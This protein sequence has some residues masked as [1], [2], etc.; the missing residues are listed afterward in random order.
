MRNN[1]FYAGV[2]QGVL[3]GIFSIIAK[4]YRMISALR[5]LLSSGCLF[6]GGRYAIARAL[7]WLLWYL[8]LYTNF[9][10]IANAHLD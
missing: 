8:P 6:L 4:I 5:S 10:A 3:N 1:T 7:S 9:I 2:N